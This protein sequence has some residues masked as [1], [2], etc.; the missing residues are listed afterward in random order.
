M[1]F[2]NLQVMTKLFNAKTLSAAFLLSV[3][4]LQAD[5][6]FLFS[7]D[8]SQ[9]ESQS[10]AVHRFSVDPQDPTE[11]TQAPS[12]GQSGSVWAVSDGK[13]YSGLAVGPD[14]DIFAAASTTKN[15]VRFDGKTGANKGVLPGFSGVADA[16]V[17]GPDGNL[18]VG[19]DSSIKRFKP[20]GTSFPAAGRLDAEFASGGYLKACTDMTF[21][22]DGNLYV[23]SQGT[24]KILRYNGQ[25][26]AFMNIFVFDNVHTPSSIAFGPD[27]NFYVANTGGPGF[28]AESG[29]VGK[30]DGRTGDFIGTFIPGAIGALGLTFG[31]NND[32]YVS[33]FWNGQ[34]SRYNA[35][36]GELLKVVQPFAPDGTALLKNIALAK[37]RDPSGS[38][39]S[40]ELKNPIVVSP[41]P[42][43]LTTLGANTIKGWQNGLLPQGEDGPLLNLATNKR[44]QYTILLPTKP[45]S[46]DE[47][48]AEDL[49]LY[50]KEMTG[51]SFPIVKEGEGE[52]RK[53]PVISIGLTR[54]L[55]QSGLDAATV[56]L[57]EEGYVIA[58]KDNNLF[59]RGGK[60]RGA[61][62]AVYTLLEEDLGCRWYAVNSLPVVP[63]A[64]VM[65]F[66]PK[67]RSFIPV[68]EL[69][70]PYLGEAF[71]TKWS[72]ENKTNSTQSV[73][74]S[75]WGGH[76]KHALFFVHTYNTLVPPEKYFENHPE[77]FAEVDGTRKSSQLCLSNKEVL[78]ISIEAVKKALRETPSAEFISVSPNDGR[79]YC[80]CAACSAVDTKEGSRAAT[81]LNFVNAVSEAITPEFPNVKVSTLAYL[82]TFMPPKTI[83]PG[84]NVVIQL[85][86]DSYAWKYQYN[87][88][89]ETE[90]FPKAIK[91]WHA[92]GAATHIWDYP[93][94]YVHYMVPMPNMPVVKDN[95]NF[96]IE[97]GAKGVMLQGVYSSSG[98]DRSYM[99]S[100]VW[101]KQLWDP[102]RDTLKLMRDFTFG[103]YG[104]AAEPMWQY[105]ELL[106]KMWEDSRKIPWKIGVTKPG[107]HPLFLEAPCSAPPDWP[108]LSPE[109]LEKANGY[110][111]QAELLA[112]D[113]ETLKKV[114]ESKISILYVQLGQALGYF[115][116]FDK[117]VAGSW[118]R[119]GDAD[120]KKRCEVLLH[121]FRENAKAAGAWSIG[122]RGRVV[123]LLKKWHEVL[124]Q[125]WKSVPTTS[126]SNQWKFRTDPT[127]LGIKNRWFSPSTPEDEWSTISSNKGKGWEGQGYPNYM[128]TAWY[129]MK[130]VVPDEF[131]NRN[132]IYLYFSAVDSECVIYL[133]G[134]LIF[135]H[136]LK[137]TGLTPETIWDRSFSVDI[138]KLLKEGQENTL[139]V[140]VN[141][142]GAIRGVWKPAFLMYN[143]ESVSLGEQ[144]QAA[145]LAK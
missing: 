23:V 19:S 90:D 74:P 130:F 71:D 65:S 133:N 106:W 25:S 73:I 127:D 11:I 49:A 17:F 9:N 119:S 144:D 59:L 21:G 135:E 132:H 42:A 78:Q 103:Y 34:I 98:G 114:K 12:T 109:F 69:R 70:D 94:N 115:D 126:L 44:T 50:L 125:E 142:A 131:A 18:Y 14:G 3:G 137:S 82:D 105:E 28:N 121:E 68:L 92:I 64:P 145:L 43:K 62:Y 45:S 101:A 138:A 80:D 124:G 27:G 63:R 139:A 116:E 84:K 87:F 107:E 37:T 33:N 102:S 26:G 136:T 76:S 67:L 30:F 40:A 97:N 143:D 13:N 38:L 20:D 56:D 113:P 81:L 83:R 122:E 48:A 5:Q 100:W 41:D 104:D 29:S 88:I 75:E 36:T 111:Q 1:H 57:G 85:C 55:T 52:D 22:P 4:S 96:Y 51:A 128:G 58:A 60:S 8:R 24:E 7:G 39:L 77:Y 6:V 129:R 89:T 141:S 2:D 10:G 31:E 72:L 47:K 110:F 79:G 108:L 53:D 16:M 140:K 32:L 118:M 15:I 54:L 35:T 99:R 93:A 86:T 46:M 61:I 95:I 112:K 91:A 123:P 134:E 120:Q 66:R 117:Y